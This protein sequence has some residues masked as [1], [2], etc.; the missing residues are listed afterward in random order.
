MAFGNPPLSALERRGRRNLA[1]SS[2]LC[3]RVHGFLSKCAS[4]VLSCHPWH[5]HSFLSSSVR[6][7]PT[8]GRLGVRVGDVGVEPNDVSIDMPRPSLDNS[9]RNSGRERLQDEGVPNVCRLPRRPSFFR[10]SLRTSKSCVLRPGGPLWDTWARSAR[11]EPTPI[12]AGVSRI[13]QKDE[14]RLICAAFGNPERGTVGFY[15]ATG[16]WSYLT[17]SRCR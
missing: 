2:G 11:S 1:A 4:F 13:M 7:E 14:C 17:A 3:R 6:T 16:H 15:D 5:G 9:F 8:H 12:V 10:M